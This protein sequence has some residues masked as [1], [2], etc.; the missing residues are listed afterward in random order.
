MMTKVAIVAMKS[1]M[2]MAYHTPPMPQNRGS[3][4]MSGNRKSICRDSERKMLIFTMPIHW[5]RLVVTIW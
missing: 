1:E 2:G 4:P 3:T 5:K